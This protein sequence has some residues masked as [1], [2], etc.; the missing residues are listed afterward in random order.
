MP[1]PQGTVQAAQDPN[2]SPL[3]PVERTRR[4][5]SPAEAH[6]TVATVVQTDAPNGNGVIPSVKPEPETTPEPAEKKGLFGDLTL[7]RAHATGH[8]V[9]LYL[10]NEGVKLRCN[11]LIH[12][13]LMGIKPDWTY[14]RGDTTRPL[15]LEK[16]DVVRETG[17]DQGKV[18]SVT[19]IRTVDATMFENGNNTGA[20]NVVANG[21]G[22]L[23]TQPDRDQ[24]VERIAIWQDKLYLRNELGQDGEIVRK[25]IDLFGTRPCFIDKAQETSLDSAR[26]IRVWLK[27]KLRPTTA[28]SDG[29]SSSRPAT[30]IAR[31]AASAGTSS[32]TGAGP[33]PQLS[34]NRAVRDQTTASERPDASSAAVGSS[35]PSS[36]SGGGF[37]IE[38]LWAQPDV[39]MIAPSKTM[40]AR[41]LLNAEFIDPPP[42]ASGA[43][44]AATPATVSSNSSVA[45]SSPTQVPAE[46]PAEQP[47]AAAAQGK[48][49]MA[50]NRA[51]QPPAEPPM[52][53]SADRVWAQLEMKPTA[54]APAGS[55][56][57]STAT[58]RRSASKSRTAST[59]SGKSQTSAEVRKLW[60]FGSVALHQDPEQGKTKGQEASGEALYLY[61]PGPNRVY[62]QIYQ[63]EPNEKTYLPGPL[64]PAR[65]ENQDMKI[66][67][68][69]TLTM[70]QETDQAWAIGP[71]VL[72]QWSSSAG[73]Q[74]PVPGS[75]NAQLTG[76]T[77]A[78]NGVPPTDPRTRSNTSLLTQSDS[79]R[80]SVAPQAKASGPK[81]KTRAGRPVSE[82]RETTIAFTERMIFD[83]RTVDPEVEGRK[84][85]RADFFGIVTARMEDGL[86]H[87]EEKLIAFTDRVV[88][89]AQLGAMAKK[90][91][92]PQVGEDVPEAA[93]SEED[94]QPQLTLMYAYTNAVGI[95]RK[96]DP[97]TPTLLQ[98]QRVEADYVLAYDHRTGDFEVPG[99]GIVYLFDRSNSSERAPGVNLDGGSKDRSAPAATRWTITPTSDRQPIRLGQS[100]DASSTAA[101][102]PRANGQPDRSSQTANRTASSKRSTAPSTQPEKSADSKANEFPSLVLTQIHFIKAMRG[103][104]RPDN[105]TKRVATNQYEFFGNIEL[106]RA[107]VPDAEA[108]L[109]ADNLPSDGFYLTAQT[110]RV[111]TEPPA[112]GSPPSTPGRDYVKAWE[113]ATVW[114]SDKVL[115]SDVITYDSRKD[116]VYAFADEGRGVN[117]AQ[118]YATGQPAT[119]GHAKAV[120]LN[121]QTGETN[122]IDNDSIALI[123]K[124]TGVRPDIAKP[125]DPDFKKEKMPRKPFRLP[126]GNIERRSFT[127][128]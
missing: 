81:S 8:A 112:A 114:N 22:R 105:E 60:M 69:G 125:V 86:L 25:I 5:S 102:A 1:A 79:E 101:T 118:Q 121:P 74:P 72:T 49:Q 23:E 91:P 71:G 107:K 12:M 97:D 37:Q 2:Q 76:A 31:A 19:H 30:G 67:T 9:W 33:V 84:T 53:G 18:T 92:K 94:S 3:K 98:Y 44:V 47:A 117:Y 99:K 119:S 116:L 50:Q 88:P 10:P 6:R 106:T 93:S 13:R 20:A 120:Q 52:V 17:P 15:D 77:T 124:N 24:P 95:S 80:G 85:G 83:G 73:D 128:Q 11:E 75:A 43:T 4:E 45:S 35:D 38:H 57:G 46:E 29:S 90:R 63:R 59:T 54:D 104:F 32:T 61:N 113:K 66:V 39:H 96:I 123:D 48:Q 58:E 108:R 64:P 14:F 100:R 27:P 41:E 16:V 21:P 68:A 127:G 70:N 110:L 26:Q 78:G 7:Q 55:S 62:T 36:T 126:T 82:L 89:L 115:Q 34:G 56:Q 87:S 40:T 51:A 42:A 65:V 111:I 122:F 109:N 103:R 28:L